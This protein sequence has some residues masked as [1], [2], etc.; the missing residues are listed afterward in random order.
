MHDVSSGV[1]ITAAIL[2]NL[3]RSREMT[4]DA[5]LSF[6]YPLQTHD[7]LEVLHSAKM[8][9]TTATQTLP[10]EATTLYYYLEVKDGG[11][12]QTYPGTAF[13]KRRKHVPHSMN[14]QDLRSVK[15]NFTLERNGFEL[16]PNAPLEEDKLDQESIEKL[17]YPKCQDLIKKM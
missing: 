10:T 3:S 6:L 5:K 11:I 1:D 13:E 14:V 7:L 12:I 9:T 16:T 15:D 8:V 17:Y 2:D 4:D